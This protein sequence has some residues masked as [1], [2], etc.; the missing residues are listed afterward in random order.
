M[1]ERRRVSRRKGI[2]ISMNTKTAERIKRV[3]GRGK[4][5]IG[6]R[7]A[8]ELSI[9][10]LLARG[11]IYKILFILAAMTGAEVALFLWS[12]DKRLRQTP[13]EYAGFVP[14]L[15]FSGAAIAFL[16]AL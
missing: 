9:W 4:T 11:S 10:T 3:E 5:H 14:V 7:F 12:L 15:N 13:L 1:S 8:R 6:A 16:A 2:G